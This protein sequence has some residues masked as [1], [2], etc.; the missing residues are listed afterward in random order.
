MK[1]NLGPPRSGL[2]F[3]VEQRLLP[4]TTIPASSIVWENEKITITADEIMVANDGSGEHRSSRDEAAEWLIELIGDGELDSKEVRSQ[5]QA[6]GLTW[7]TVRRAKSWLG[8]K[9]QRR[10]DGSAGEGKWVWR[11]PPERLQGAQKSQGAHVPDMSTLGGFEHLGDR[12][13][14]Q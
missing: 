3:R 8:I 4:N 5:S 7:A 10:S 13:G 9:P 11:L 6:A 1:N 12:E 2:A 14:A